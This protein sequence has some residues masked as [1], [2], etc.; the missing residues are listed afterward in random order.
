MLGILRLAHLVKGIHIFDDLERSGRYRH[1][2][3]GEGHFRGGLWMWRQE[4][5][6]LEDRVAGAK[7]RLMKEGLEY[8]AKEPSFY[9]V[10]E[11]W[12]E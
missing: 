1:M 7:G 12:N 6:G 5:T 11:W 9:M 8:T 10:F 2:Q 3:I 4:G